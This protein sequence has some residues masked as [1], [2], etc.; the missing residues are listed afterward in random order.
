MKFLLFCLY[1][2]L[3]LH[4]PVVVDDSFLNWLLLL[5]API[6]NENDALKNINGIMKYWGEAGL[7]VRVQNLGG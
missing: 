4:L 3:T 1:V 2:K 5:L 6:V 7:E